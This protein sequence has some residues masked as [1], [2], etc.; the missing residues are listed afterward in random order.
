MSRQDA[1]C[2]LQVKSLCSDSKT[3]MDKAGGE[4]I[5]KLQSQQ[6]AA[7]YTEITT[8]CI[9]EQVMMGTIEEKSRDQAKSDLLLV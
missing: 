6:S 2:S 3:W 5:K 8:A 1:S 4:L 7:Q 9:R